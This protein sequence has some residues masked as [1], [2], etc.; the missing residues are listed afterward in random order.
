M[1]KA[2]TRD[3][4]IATR[5]SDLTEGRGQTVII[6]FFMEEEDAV[7]AVKGQGT[8]GVGDGRVYLFSFVER[9][10]AHP[11][12]HTAIASGLSLFDN[13]YLVYGYHRSLLTGDFRTGYVDGRDLPQ[14][15]PEFTEFLRLKAKFDPAP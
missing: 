1:A 3:F 8:M 15:D 7:A 11:D 10:L 6:G 12:D 4:F 5:N 14:N 13:R 9:V 2:S